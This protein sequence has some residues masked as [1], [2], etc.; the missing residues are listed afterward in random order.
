MK[1]RIILLTSIALANCVLHCVVTLAAPMGTAFTYQGRFN[2]GGS[3]ANGA[4][5]FEFKLFDAATAG[6]QIGSTVTKADLAV[7]D[8]YFT[9]TLDFGSSRFTGDARWLQIA[10]R[11]GAETG[12]Y[13]TLTPRHE[14]TPTPYAINSDNEGTANYI[15]KFTSTGMANS[16]LYE[17][18]GKIGIATTTPASTLDLGAGQEVVP[19]VVEG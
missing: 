8:G 17:S 5:D 14:L 19:S 3:P 9:T 13:T 6:N 2:A 4:Y 10:V 11:P 12:S 18:S 16:V 1:S 15:P 7:S